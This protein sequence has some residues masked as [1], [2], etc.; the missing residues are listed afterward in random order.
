MSLLDKLITSYP[1][2][3]H[4]RTQLSPPHPIQEKWKQHSYMI[5]VY[6]AN[7]N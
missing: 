7:P 1:T 5:K 3:T 6:Y 4:Q 2:A